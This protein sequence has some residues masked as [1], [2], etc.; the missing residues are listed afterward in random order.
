MQD[1]LNDLHSIR[2][3]GNFNEE[4]LS[5]IHIDVDTSQIPAGLQL[6][7]DESDNIKGQI[8]KLRVHIESLTIGYRSTLLSFNSSL[9][10]DLNHDLEATIEA[11]MKSIGNDLKNM[12]EEIKASTEHTKW[13]TNVH[14]LLTKRF[15][16]ILASY[17]TLQS[18]HQENVKERIRQ[19]A[20][21]INPNAT[22]DELDAVMNTGSLNLFAVEL[23]KQRISV[24]K[25]ALN[26]VEDRHREVLKIEQSVQELCQLFNEMAILVNA[27]GEY[28]DNI[29]ENVS[30]SVVNVEEA[31]K[32]LVQA[33]KY[34]SRKR[35]CL[36]YS[37][38]GCIVLI[39]IGFVI[40]MIF[41][42]KANWWKDK[43]PY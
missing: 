21:I 26:Y 37:C 33:M 13:K 24:A 42:S 10:E 36:C 40:L 22:Q 25:D 3:S 28:I 2:D 31:N 9:Q 18:E 6:F 38:I 11:E 32:H 8:E 1:R 29:M 4:E 43:L 14:A 20:L 23:Q 15:M 7:N 41:G 34:Q 35:W 5:E 39:A 19:R 16:D 30:L 17:R 27:Q 12:N